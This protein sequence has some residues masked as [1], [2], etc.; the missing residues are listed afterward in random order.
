MITFE[1]LQ[2]IKV[3]T[4]CWLD[5]CCSE[6]YHKLIAIDLSKQQVVDANP[7]AIQHVNFPG[8]LNGAEGATM[9]FII[10]EAEETAFDFS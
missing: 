3:M 10:K 7:K 4:G 6:K 9:F 1:N 5:Y 8:N 2:L